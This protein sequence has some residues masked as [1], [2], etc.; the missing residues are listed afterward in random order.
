MRVRTVCSLSSGRR[1]NSV[2]PQTSQTPGT[3]VG[4]NVVVIAGAALGAGE[5]AGDPLHQLVLVDDELDHMVEMT[6]ALGEQ[7]VERFGLVLGA[8][9]AVE[10]RALVRRQRRAAR[11]SAR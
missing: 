1:L 10:D 5:A 8:R 7:H 4:R 9:K 2:D 3:L 6:P 11:R